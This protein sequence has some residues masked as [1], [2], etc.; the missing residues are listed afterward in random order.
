VEAYPRSVE[1]LLI[2][3]LEAALDLSEQERQAIAGLPMTIR[4]LKARQDIV[5]TGDRPTQCCLILSGLAYRFMLLGEGKRQIFSF[6]IPGEIPDLQ[7]LHLAV[8][9]HDV[10]TVTAAKVAFIPHQSLHQLFACYPRL[11]ASF[12]RDTLVDAAIFRVWMAGMGRRSAYCRTAHLFC[13]LATR[14]RAVGLA[15][16]DGFE[17]PETQEELADALGL[18]TVHLNRTLKHLKGDGLV[19]TERGWLKI[20]DWEGLKQAGEFEPTYL[21][22]GDRQAMP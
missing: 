21:H 10:A 8:M 5:R 14:Y 3:R 17:L 20:L 9:D 4:D 11:A 7:S 22:L 13:E 6:H 12:W 18:S 15:G 2:R 16:A 1:N 19:A